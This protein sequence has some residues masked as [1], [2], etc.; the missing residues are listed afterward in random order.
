MSYSIEREM[1]PDIVVWLDRY[2]RERFR[3]Q[4]VKTTDSSRI[5]TSSVL[6]QEQLAPSNKPDHASYDI[7]VDVTS[8]ISSGDHVELAFV[9]C[10]LKQ[11]SL[12]DVSQL[13]GYSRVANPVFSCILSPQGI[14][15]EVSALLRT[16]GRSEIL[17]YDWPK[18][19][20][21]RSICIAK[22]DQRKQD[23]DYAT[24]LPSGFHLQTWLTDFHT[25]SVPK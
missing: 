21:P 8:V 1:Y 24:L 6:Q 7:R 5:R 11:I 17:E 4:K 15:S 2:I 13:L 25:P 9:E 12:R 3:K 16:Y 19:E 20:T 10:K 14:S 18:G 23:I 22:W